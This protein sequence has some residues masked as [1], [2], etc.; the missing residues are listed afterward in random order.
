MPM[1]TARE[2]VADQPPGHQ[3]AISALKSFF[4]DQSR[5][6]GRCG[7]GTTRAN[8][9]KTEPGCTWQRLRTPPTTTWLRRTDTP[10]EAILRAIGG[11]D[12]IGAG[13]GRDRWA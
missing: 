4:V 5:H 13:G 11:Y 2:L 9:G 12:D 7:Q 1:A 10:G 3:T 8:T 6:R